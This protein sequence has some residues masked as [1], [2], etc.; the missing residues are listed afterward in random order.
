MTDKA[1][2]MFDPALLADMDAGQAVETLVRHAADLEAS[3]LFFLMDEGSLSVSMR[4][5]GSVEQIAFVSRDQ[6]RQLINHAKAMSG[7]DIAQRNRPGEGRWLLDQ[8]G[9]RLD[10]RVSSIST[11]F[12]EDMAMRIWD[13]GVG[14]RQI[15]DLG[16]TRKDLQNLKT[17]LSR[18]SGLILVTGP[19]GT[20][21]TTTLYACLQYLTDG[22]RKINTLEDPIEFALDNIRQSQI[23]PKSGTDFPELLRAVL[24]QA[25]DV[26]MIGEVRDEETATAAVRAA[27][28]GHLVLA[29]LHAPVA[30]NAV[31]SM[32][33]LGTQPYFLSSC[34]LGVVAQRLV[35]T[36]CPECRMEFDVSEAPEI[37]DAVRDLLEEGQGGTLAG[38]GGCEAC[39]YQGYSGR[40]GVFEIMLLNQELRKLL[41]NGASTN[42][43]EAAAIRN[44]M[45]EFKR[46]AMLK[47]AAGVTSTE[48]ILRDVPAE[49]LGIE[50]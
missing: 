21:K 25:P 12:G 22:R 16:M 19:T 48:E 23:H 46:G 24:R 8:D 37:F 42:E 34:L 27:N 1:R 36:L 13:R 11:L 14:L 26:I 40:T 17:L 6:G 2:R 4:R 33:A 30:A 41:A 28:S 43:V 32:L 47:V 31:Q 45:V 15:T 44:G 49:Y 3:D 39:Q 18:P 35:R 50:D 29:T 10:L 9:R 7:M 20:G 38:P 5:L